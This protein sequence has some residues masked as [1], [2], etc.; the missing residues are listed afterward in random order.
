MLFLSGLQMASNGRLSPTNSYERWLVIILNDDD[1]D[2][3]INCMET[4]EI[5][6]YFSILEYTSRK[7]CPKKSHSKLVVVLLTSLN[8]SR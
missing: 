8:C 5:I 3:V 2:G 4:C 6:V 7:P 1:G